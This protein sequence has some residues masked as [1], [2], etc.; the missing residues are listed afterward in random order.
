[1]IFDFLLSTDKLI[2]AT[3]RSQFSNCTVLTVAHRLNTIIDNDRV[4]VLDAGSII[5]FDSPKKLF[6][7]GNA[8]YKLIVQAG[9]EDK[10]Q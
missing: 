2:Q 1:M 8:F 5:E 4:M 7:D 3:I 9:M 6:D 10:L